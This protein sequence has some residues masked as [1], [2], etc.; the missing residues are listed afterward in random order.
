MKREWTAYTEQEVNEGITDLSTIVLRLGGV[1]AIAAFRVQGEDGEYSVQQV[2]FKY[3][4]YA[5]G[6]NARAPERE[7]A[8][9]AEANGK[10]DEAE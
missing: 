10:P 1:G 6:H 8:V 5:P 9:V 3:D 7:A 4:S 2:I